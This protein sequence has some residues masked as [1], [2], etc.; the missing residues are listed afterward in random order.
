MGRECHHGAAKILNSCLTVERHHLWAQSLSEAVM[1]DHN[2]WGWKGSVLEGPVP[3][4]TPWLSF[5]PF[6]G[7]ELGI[8]WEALDEIESRTGLEKKGVMSEVDDGASI[9][10]KS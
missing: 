5:C 4:T 9:V 8:F 6:R 2:P 7:T 1:K 10:V 3:T